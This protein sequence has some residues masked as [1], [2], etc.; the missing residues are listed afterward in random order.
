MELVFKYSQ[1]RTTAICCGVNDINYDGEVIIPK[2][3]SDVTVVSISPSA[4]SKTH[5]SSVHIP[6]T[7]KSIGMQAF[8]YC[9]NLEQVTF[10]EESSLEIIDPL[11]FS[12]CDKLTYIRLPEKLRVIERLAFRNCTCEFSNR[13]LV[14]TPNF[15]G[16]KVITYEPNLPPLAPVEQDELGNKYRLNEAGDGY[17][18]ETLYAK[19]DVIEV[20]ETF[21]GLPVV[22]LGN[23]AFTW[24]TEA[25]KAIIP[26]SV[27]KAGYFPFYACDEMGYAEY[28]GTVKEW[29][30]MDI[31]TWFNVQCKDGMVKGQG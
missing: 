16:C 13:C 27:K 4:F 31:Y 19:E 9:D 11:A 8:A 15:E 25:W 29:T 26:A 30:E 18:V 1:D 17:I 28:G 10:E 6:N 14:M 5:I 22:E 20:P 21:N 12:G 3:Q 7:V 2:F 23:M 24:N